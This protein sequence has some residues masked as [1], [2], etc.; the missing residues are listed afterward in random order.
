MQTAN[1]HYIHSTFPGIFL[2]QRVC[3]AFELAHPWPGWVTNRSTRII[4]VV[5]RPCEGP[6][7][8]GPATRSCRRM[9]Q[10][11]ALEARRH[12]R[13]GNRHFPGTPTHFF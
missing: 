10:R 9:R 7:R 13:Q 4:V 1:K 2:P 3:H 6:G 12:I 11:Y 5:P 8:Y